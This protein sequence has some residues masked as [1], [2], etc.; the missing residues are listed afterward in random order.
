M[1]DHGLSVYVFR[2]ADCTD[3]Q[4][5]GRPCQLHPSWFVHAGRVNHGRCCRHIL[6][7][8]LSDPGVYPDLRRHRGLDLLHISVEE[9]LLIMGCQPLLVSLDS[10]YCWLHAILP[11]E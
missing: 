11:A 2:S 10:D 5:E 1:V 3:G 8:A 4:E 6:H 7:C 9:G